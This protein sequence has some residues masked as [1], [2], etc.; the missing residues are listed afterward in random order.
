MSAILSLD[1]TGEFGSIALIEGDRVVEEVPL[2]SPDGFG[3][4]LFGQIDRLLNRHA[5]SLQRIDCFAAA[6]GP[7]SFTG[8][9]VGLA[10]AKGLAESLE[11][12]VVAVSN[13]AALAWFGS[14][15]VRAALLDARRGEVYGGVFDRDL[16]EIAP[17]TVARFADWIASLPD[18]DLQFITPLRAL[19]APAL[20]ATRFRTAELI[21]APR[22]IAGA[23]GLIA[24]SR[25]RAGRAQDP[26][27]VDANY[28]RRSDAE[29]LWQDR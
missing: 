2:H 18:V 27:A 25:F 26:A 10:A 20:A 14:A 3:H 7:G 5:T 8:V 1:S 15:D 29:L 16:A 4:I 17:E 19:F 28:V 6:S 12:P 24:A 23:I 22:A 11:K 21:E 9:R 13:L